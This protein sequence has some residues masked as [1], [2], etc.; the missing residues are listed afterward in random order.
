MEVSGQL[1]TI[2]RVDDETNT[3]A[4]ILMLAK[5]TMSTTATKTSS[6]PNSVHNVVVSAFVRNGAS[7]VGATNLRSRGKRVQ[8]GLSAALHL[9]ISSTTPS[10]AGA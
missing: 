2:G 4:S 9:F 5:P 7:K 3:Y 10:T 6:P 1:N 8:P